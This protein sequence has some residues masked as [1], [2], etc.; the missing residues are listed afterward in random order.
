MGVL[1][2]QIVDMRPEGEM[3]VMSVI[4]SML[5][6]RPETAASI[7]SPILPFVV[8]YVIVNGEM[9]VVYLQYPIFSPFFS[10]LQEPA[11][12]FEHS[13]HYH[14]LFFDHITSRPRFQRCILSGEFKL[15]A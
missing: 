6:N 10:F 11:G 12:R 7:V 13:P 9:S 1:T 14:V 8:S 3:R 4:E 5:V 2:D 15:K